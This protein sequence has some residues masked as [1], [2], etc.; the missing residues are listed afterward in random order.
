MSAAD[1]ATGPQIT[2]VTAAPT[3]LLDGHPFAAQF[4]AV[5][6]GARLVAHAHRA[7]EAGEALTVRRAMAALMDVAQT[8]PPEP[9]GGIFGPA[10]RA[11]LAVIHAYLQALTTGGPDWTTNQYLAEPG[12]DWAL[13]AA[14][15]SDRAATFTARHVTARGTERFA[16]EVAAR[17]SDT[18]RAALLPEVTR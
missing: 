9:C 7:A 10:H 8:L 3:P 5:E 6:T 16:A 14:A 15:Y 17:A 1:P 12:T 11:A 2:P 18:V 4:V 13:A